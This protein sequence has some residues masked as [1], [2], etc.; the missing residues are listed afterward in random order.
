MQEIASDTKV[1]LCWVDQMDN[2]EMQKLAQFGAGC[3]S[4]VQRQV[5]TSA[6][7][8]SNISFTTGLLGLFW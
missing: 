5:F 3:D 2:A 8:L 6:H 4:Q 7:M 1:H